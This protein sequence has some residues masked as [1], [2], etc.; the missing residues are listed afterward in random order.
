MADFDFLEEFGV[1]VG[2][3]EQPQSVYEKFILK[4]GNQVTADLREYIQQKIGRA[5]VWTPVT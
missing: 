3:A 2:E 4:V 5:H 1:S